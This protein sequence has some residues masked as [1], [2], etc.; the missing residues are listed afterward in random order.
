MV[1][2]KSTGRYEGK[3][4][5]ER[6]LPTMLEKAHGKRILEWTLKVYAS[7]GA[8]QFKNSRL[9]MVGHFDFPCI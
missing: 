8:Q 2:S 9:K 3:I 5:V 6:S 4:S 1:K 7:V